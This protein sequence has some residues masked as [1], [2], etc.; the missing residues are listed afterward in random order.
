MKE[1]VDGMGSMPTTIWHPS[2]Q[3]MRRIEQ[4]EEY[5]PSV[6]IVFFLR[7]LP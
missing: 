6:A 7:E 2:N 1:W 3:S 5:D 4:N